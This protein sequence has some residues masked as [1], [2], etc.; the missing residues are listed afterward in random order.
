MLRSLKISCLVALALVI[1]A[2]SGCG[3][4]IPQTTHPKGTEPLVSPSHT[5]SIPEHEPTVAEDEGEDLVEPSEVDAY[6][7]WAIYVNEEHGF[8]FHFPDT[9]KIMEYEGEPF[10]SLKQGNL[11][12]IIGVKHRSEDTNIFINRTESLEQMSEVIFLGQVVPRM[13]WIQDTRV[14]AVRY[15]EPVGTLWGGE[16]EADNL[17]FTLSLWEFGED[18]PN[19]ANISTDVQFEVDQIV[20]SFELNE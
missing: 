7:G 3:K 9:W 12:F 5:P 6:E 10:I 4:S 19:T 1:I 13:V 20:S 8:S 2:G 16:I 18:W 14:L 11:E 17:V 15:G